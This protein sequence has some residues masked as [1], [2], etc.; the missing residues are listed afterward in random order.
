MSG[1]AYPK[2]AGYKQEN[3]LTAK[4][5]TLSHWWPWQ[6]KAVDSMTHLSQI[7]TIDKPFDDPAFLLAIG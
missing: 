2:A 1:D 4:Q 6:Q 3:K 5:G 7:F